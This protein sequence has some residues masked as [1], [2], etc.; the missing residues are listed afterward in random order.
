MGDRRKNRACSISPQDWLER[1]VR[2]VGIHSRNGLG[3]GE[4]SAVFFDA[5]KSATAYRTRFMQL[6]VTKQ[7]AWEN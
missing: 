1:R 7:E 2:Q 3:T 4:S 5:A 6:F